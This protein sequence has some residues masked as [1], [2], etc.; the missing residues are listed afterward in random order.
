MNERFASLRTRLVLAFMLVSVPPML[1]A[2]YVAARL[3]SSAFEQNVEE[4][5]ADTTRFFKLQISE[6]ESDASRVAA[7]LANR[8]A[9]AAIVDQPKP[10]EIDF[11]LIMSLGYDLIVIYDESKR[12]RYASQPFE[13]L[14]V[15]PME[16]QSSVFAVRLGGDHKL[17]AGAVQPYRVGSANYYVLVGTWLDP[18]FLRT[19]KVVTTL[20]LRMYYRDGEA[21]F[22]ATTVS[23]NEAATPPPPGLLRKLID[24]ED[25]VFDQSDEFYAAAY[26]GLLDGS[27]KI[28]GVIFCGL[29]AQEGLFTQIGGPW[30]FTGLFL[31]GVL[32]STLAGLWVSGR[33]VRPLKALSRGVRSITAGD[34]QQ[35]IAEVGGTEVEELARNFNVMAEQFAKVRSLEAELRRRDRL[36]ALGEAAMVIAHEVRNPLGI[37]QTSAQVVRSKAGL[38]AADERL[39]GY[40]VDEVRRIEGLIREFLDFARPKEPR[41]ELVRLRDVLDRVAAFAEPEFAQRHIIFVIDDA[42]PDAVVLGDEDQLYQACLNL[43]L[44]AIDALPAGGRII[45]ALRGDDGEVAVTI[46]DSGSGVSAEIAGRL[47]D[48]FF[49][50]KAKGSGLGLTKVQTIAEAH[51]GRVEYLPSKNGGAAFRIVLPRAETRAP[52]RQRIATAEAP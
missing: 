38:T 26:A 51:R 35:R 48:P 12:V 49:T 45:G 4:W 47:F 30:L 21:L 5:L 19:I 18:D 7:V 36:S 16:A 13:A 34:Y 37:I 1:L 3:I 31:A 46:S 42:A 17:M 40:V 15:M 41:M 25:P 10:E 29:G 43:V 32:L 2:A 20:E 11:D 39:L 28:I 8:L 22:P 27:G 23:G 14:S 44:N 6:A 24:G 33:L 50:T 52:A 9:A